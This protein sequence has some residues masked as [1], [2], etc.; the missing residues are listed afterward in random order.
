MHREIV[1]EC[2][3]PSNVQIVTGMDGIEDHPIDEM[4]RR[5]VKVDN[6]LILDTT[7]S[8]DLLKWANTFGWDQ[9]TIERVCLNG[10]L[11]GAPRGADTTQVLRPE[12]TYR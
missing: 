6:T 3:P 5:G 7:A 4:Y 2:C 1:F 9:E 11:R 12:K 8:R 10:Q